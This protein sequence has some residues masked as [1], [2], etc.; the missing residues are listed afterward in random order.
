MSSIS[1]K[2]KKLNEDMVKNPVYLHHKQENP[3]IAVREI[4]FF[5][6]N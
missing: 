1:S 3:A 6:L 5:D 4:T 2:S